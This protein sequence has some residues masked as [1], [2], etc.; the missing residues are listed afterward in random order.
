M[1]TGEECTELWTHL[2]DRK[3]EKEGMGGRKKK[4]TLLAKHCMS[5]SNRG[6]NF[7]DLRTVN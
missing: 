6:A 3:W 7:Q 2:R 1:K 4:E 5:S